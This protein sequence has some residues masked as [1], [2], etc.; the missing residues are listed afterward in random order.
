[1]LDR[2]FDTLHEPPLCSREGGAVTVVCQDG[3]LH[4]AFE[5]GMAPEQQLHTYGH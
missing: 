3:I 1:M 2:D 4:Q 5:V